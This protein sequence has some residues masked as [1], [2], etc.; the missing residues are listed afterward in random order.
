L[1]K[2]GDQ[3]INRTVQVVVHQLDI[4]QV[5]LLVLPTGVG[6]PALDDL[7]GVGRSPSEPLLED[8]EAGD[9]HEDE[10]GRRDSLL[11]LER[12]LDINLQ[13][14]AFLAGEGL[15]NG[16]GGSPIESAVYLGPFKEFALVA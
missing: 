13:E 11:D 14:D 2:S 12:S 3:V 5:R 8:L 15:S 4:V 7:F 1:N 10:Q 16:A 9:R 6:Q